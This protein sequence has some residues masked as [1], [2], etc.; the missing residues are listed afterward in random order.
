MM[1]QSE[2]LPP[3]I[4]W[5]RYA[6]VALLAAVALGQVWSMRAMWKP[7][8]MISRFAFDA[9][10]C[11]LSPS[12]PDLTLRVARHSDG[13]AESLLTVAGKQIRISV[14]HH[15][16]T[17]ALFESQRDA[18]RGI[19]RDHI[20]GAPTFRRIGGL[21]DPYQFGGDL[22]VATWPAQA[23]GAQALRRPVLPRSAACMPLA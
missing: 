20:P 3:M 23:V 14:L 4:G 21:V 7:S 15:A 17:E 16:P 10:K 12:A 11:A 13:A 5:V 19:V 1:E 6:A 8:T 9:D 2:R 22:L 18:L